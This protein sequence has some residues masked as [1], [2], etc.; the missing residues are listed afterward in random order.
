MPFFAAFVCLS[1]IYTQQEH[2]HS[3]RPF[4]RELPLWLL[5][6]SAVIAAQFSRGRLSYMA[7]MF[8]GYFAAERGLILDNQVLRQNELMLFSFLS[9]IT[10]F[11]SLS[12]DRGLA[13]V[14]TLLNLLIIGV[15]FAA[16]Y[17]WHQY[18]SDILG[19]LL[20]TAPPL[21]S[22]TL[23]DI[24]PWL[25]CLLLICAATVRTGGLTAAAIALSFA[26][27]SLKY[28]YP[29]LFPT[30]ILLTLLAALY[31]ISVLSD[32]YTLAYRDE[33]TN[34]PS[35][36]ALYNLVLSLGPK[37]SVAMIDID[38]FKKFND[39]YGHDVGDQVLRLVAGKLSDI[40]GGG[41][42]F[43][44]GGEE[45]TVV[46]SRK[47]SADTLEHLEKVRQSVE[48][49]HITLRGHNRKTA[50]TVS[51]TISAGVAE[52]GKGERFEQTLKRA[53][54]ALYD[55]KKKGRN[56]VCIRSRR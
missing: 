37:Y 33:L 31:L 6:V 47:S 2:W 54:S 30:S 23:L 55:A 1:A 35:R 22:D 25:I 39:T 3:W 42:V 11:L 8:T 49:Y 40:T 27:W 26:V 14:F 46:F 4:L 53:D 16:A 17:L 15:L 43:R 50:K 51:V 10:A 20:V 19:L 7:L 13:S 34:L 28:F 21:A 38:H 36:R 45:F 56:Q 29:A 5:P 32:S 12:K 44:Y 52:H 9:A 48:A 24:L 18:Q 41:K